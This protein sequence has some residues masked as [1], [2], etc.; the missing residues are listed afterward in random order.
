MHGYTYIYIM[1]N[2]YRKAAVMRLLFF[3]QLR[4]RAPSQA[5]PSQGNRGTIRSPP[6][7]PEERENTINLLFSSALLPHKCTPKTPNDCPKD[8][9]GRPR[10]IQGSPRGAQRMPSG[11]P[12]APHTR[13]TSIFHW[14]CGRSSDESACAIL[15][16][17]MP[18]DVP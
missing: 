7:K 9:K 1:L 11:T 10:I 14:T 13:K 5:P 16:H 18:N 17:Q 6:K 15:A 3:L 2:K 8:S 4:F 12:R